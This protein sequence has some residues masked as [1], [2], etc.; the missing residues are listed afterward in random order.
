MEHFKTRLVSPPPAV[1][2]HARPLNKSAVL[3]RAPELRCD[4]FLLSLFLIQFYDK[5]ESTLVGIFRKK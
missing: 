5:V 1:P 3:S 4:P 2:P